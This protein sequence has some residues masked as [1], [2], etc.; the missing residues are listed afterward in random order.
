VKGQ[1]ST[2]IASITGAGNAHTVRWEDSTSTHGWAVITGATTSSWNYTPAKTGDRLRVVVTASDQCS[3]IVQKVSDPITFTVNAVTA[4]DPDPVA[5]YGVSIFPNPASD[6][7]YLR[8]LNLSHQWQSLSI[9]G[10][11]GKRIIME[12]DIR[13][14]TGVDLAVTSVPSGMYMLVLTGKSGKRA[15]YKVILRR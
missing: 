6:V 5:E 11:D 1:S 7:L 10:M 3:G 9:T 4:I 8:N 15:Y 12:K 2:I 13:G 14:V